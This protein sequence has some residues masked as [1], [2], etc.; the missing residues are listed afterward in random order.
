MYSPFTKITYTLTFPRCLFGAVSRSYLKCYFPGY[1]PHFASHKTYSHV[2][3][4]FLGGGQ[5]FQTYKVK[6]ILKPKSEKDTARKENF[7]PTTL[8]THYRCKNPK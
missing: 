7:R 1:S 3:Q 4:F 5:H 6:I 8:M 2:V